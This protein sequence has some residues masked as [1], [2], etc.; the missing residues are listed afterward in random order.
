MTL[1]N[2]I[3]FNLVGLSPAMKKIADHFLSHF[4]DLPFESAESIADA[5][6]VSSISVGRYLRQL[7]FQNMDDFRLSLKTQ[8][9]PNWQITDRLAAH[10]QRS[11][12]HL[13]NDVSLLRNIQHLQQAHYLRT[14]TAY[15]NMLQ[16]MLHAEAVYII[17]IQSCRGLMLYFYSLLEYMRPNVYYSDGNSGAFIDVFNHDKKTAYVLLADIRSYAVHSRRL[18]LAAESQQ[19]A[20]GLITDVYC[21]WAA[22]LTGDVVTVETDTQQFW[23]STLPILTLL[24]SLLN[25]MAHI[26]GSSLQQRIEKNQQLQDHFKQ[27]EE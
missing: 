2:K 18:C 26:L 3:Q 21:P 23:D 11:P 6:G 24:Q 17:G 7:G 19:L 15:Q 12:N 22:T 9:H 25:D 20:Y 14:Q 13:S 27:F 10:M 5:V 1:Y 16:Q 4:D 8:L